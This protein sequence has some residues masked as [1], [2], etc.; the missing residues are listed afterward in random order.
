MKRKISTVVLF[1]LL[2][3]TVVA[4]QKVDAPQAFVGNIGDVKHATH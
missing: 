2:F 3:L 1:V 4:L